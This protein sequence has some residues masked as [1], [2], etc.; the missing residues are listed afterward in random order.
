M[1]ESPF[2]EYQSLFYISECKTPIF[3]FIILLLKQDEAKLL[4]SIQ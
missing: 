2:I 1:C 4:Q 3:G